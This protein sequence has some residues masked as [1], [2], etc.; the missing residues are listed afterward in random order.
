MPTI[1]SK[2][3]LNTGARW[4]IETMTAALV[5]LNEK[6][7]ENILR[8]ALATAK[9]IVIKM[10]DLTALSINKLKRPLGNRAQTAPGTSREAQRTKGGPSRA[11]LDLAAT[12]LKLAA[13]KPD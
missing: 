9:E 11:V 7:Q 10:E 8:I 2:A 4:Q 13:A 1:S 3:R 6:R 5:N 12:F